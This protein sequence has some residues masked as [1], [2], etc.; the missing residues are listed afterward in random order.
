VHSRVRVN[1]QPLRRHRERVR[2]WYPSTLAT[3]AKKAHQMSFDVWLAQFSDRESKVKDELAAAWATRSDYE[4]WDRLI[5]LECRTV[6][7]DSL[8]DVAVEA[9]AGT[10]EG[11][12]PGE[13]LLRLAAYVL[14]RLLQRVTA[15]QLWDFLRTAGFSPPRRGPHPIGLPTAP[16]A[17][18]AD[19]WWSEVAVR[20]PG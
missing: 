19:S 4:F 3:V 10:V 2:V 7:G 11:G 1:A 12:D 9:L 20:R 17:A 16:T 15:A 18:E 14:D 8:R 6:D 13:A 5:R